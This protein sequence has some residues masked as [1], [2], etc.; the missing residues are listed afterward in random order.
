MKKIP[1]QILHR[2]RAEATK[3]SHITNCSLSGKEGDAPAQPLMVQGHQNRP[4]P[5]HQLH[6]CSS[7]QGLFP[8]S[9]LWP[10]TEFPASPNTKPFPTDMRGG[11]KPLNI[12][13]LCLCAASPSSALL[14]ADPVPDASTSPST[15]I[16]LFFRNGNFS[17]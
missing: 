17:F 9:V 1:A 3:F 16:L 7:D 5:S 8:P 12:P 13:W 2:S 14:S 11:R 4:H 10:M 6:C 15:K